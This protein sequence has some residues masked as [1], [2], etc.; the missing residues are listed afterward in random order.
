MAK[1]G[2][3]SHDEAQDA[4]MQMQCMHAMHCKPP[5]SK[6]RSCTCK[7]VALAAVMLRKRARQ[8]SS[9]IARGLAAGAGVAPGGRLPH[10]GPC[11]PLPP[12]PPTASS[13]LPWLI[14]LLIHT[15]ERSQPGCCLWASIADGC[16]VEFWVAGVQTRNEGLHKH[17]NKHC[18]KHFSERRTQGRGV[19]L[20]H[21]VARLPGPER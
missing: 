9:L 11:R 4:C 6:R 1:K 19:L 12:T 17:S 16:G 14:L 20:C 7:V 5:T 8:A 18:N 21:H 13:Q 2:A 3:R 10:R 15:I